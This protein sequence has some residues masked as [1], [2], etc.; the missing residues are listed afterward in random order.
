MRH[1]VV[2]LVASVV[3]FFVLFCFFPPEKSSKNYK[4]MN[5]M[6]LTVIIALVLSGGRLRKCERAARDQERDCPLNMQIFSL[7]FHLL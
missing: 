1:N 2:L 6:A 4:H 5:T 7:C 3:F